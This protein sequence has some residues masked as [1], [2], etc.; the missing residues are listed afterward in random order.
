[1]PTWQLTHKIGAVLLPV[2]GESFA[3]INR[4]AALPE[5]DAPPVSEIALSV[6]FSP[7]ENWR[8]AHAG[9]YWSRINNIYPH[10]ETQP[11]L[12]SQI[13]KFG[14]EFWVQPA[15]R[16]EFVNP[17][18]SRSWFIADPPT[19]LIQVQRDR[20]VINWRQIKGDETYPRYSA[21]MR[22]RFEREWN[23]FRK[24]VV[25]AKIGSIAVQ[26]C[27]VTYR[28]E[29]L[30]GKGWDVF[31]E[32]LTLFAPWWKDGTDGFLPR[33][34]SLSVAGSFRMPG[35]RGR[36]H[37]SAQHALRATDK[38]EIIQFQLVARG[39]PVSDST[40]DIL[41]WLDIGHEWVVR[42]FSDLTSKR[43]HEIWKR[44]S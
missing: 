22:P 12:P 21:E 39:R 43:A 38:K 30:Q 3:M 26:Q 40:A 10:S 34:E 14:D 29:L 6:E 20:F 16:V 42:G 2:R 27:E 19:K 41:N 36:L 15:V 24:F 32:S 13:E 35:D 4:P 18:I 11:P 5:F 7:L 28:N 9:L 33:P 44:K 23:D 8:G 1:V 17:D 25:E 31:S 37:F